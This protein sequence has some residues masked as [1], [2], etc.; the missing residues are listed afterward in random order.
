MRGGFAF[1]LGWRHYLQGT[2]RGKS[3]LRLGFSGFRR[4]CKTREPE[5]PRLT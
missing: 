4:N 5:Q 1:G 3:D 2:T